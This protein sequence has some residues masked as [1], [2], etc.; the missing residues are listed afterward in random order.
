MKAFLSRRARVTA[1]PVGG[2][3]QGWVNMLHSL[4][5]DFSFPEELDFSVP[6]SPCHNWV[7]SFTTTL[8]SIYEIIKVGWSV[9]YKNIYFCPKKRHTYVIMAN[10]KVTGYIYFCQGSSST[11]NVTIWVFMKL[12]PLSTV[13]KS[14]ETA[15]V[16]CYGYPVQT[17]ENFFRTALWCPL[18]DRRKTSCVL[19]VCSGGSLHFAVTDLAKLLSMRI[20]VAIIQVRNSQKRKY[21]FLSFLVSFQKIER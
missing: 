6:Q 7:C 14:C 21:L 11:A 20:L 5:L 1:Q 18:K 12:N 4:T 15:R 13:V 8:E 10:S 9:F 3:A 2:L 17:W 16:S 19:F